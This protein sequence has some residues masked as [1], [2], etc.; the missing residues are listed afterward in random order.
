MAENKG[1]KYTISIIIPLL[2]IVA[3]AFFVV[4]SAGKK[5][6]GY[7]S[8]A[9]ES[10]YIDAQ[11]VYNSN[12]NYG[13]LKKEIEEYAARVNKELA[14]QLAREHNEAKRTELK[15]LA[16]KEIELYAET[17]LQD[18]DKDV[19]D[20]INEVAENKNLKRV[21]ISGSVR[22]NGKNMTQAVITELN[23]TVMQRIGGYFDE[24]KE[25]QTKQ[26]PNYE[27]QFN[28]DSYPVAKVPEQGVT[29]EASGSLAMKKKKGSIVAD[30]QLQPKDKEERFVWKQKE[31][32]TAVK[33]APAT[34]EAEKH[35][36][37]QKIYA[38][39]GKIELPSGK[40]E[41]IA[42]G[43]KYALSN[44]I[45]YIQ[46]RNAALTELEIS[47]SNPVG[48]TIVT[49]KTA[50]KQL[51]T[52]INT[53]I[54]PTGVIASRPSQITAAHVSAILN[55]VADSYPFA[56]ASAFIQAKNAALT[57]LSMSVPKPSGKNTVAA[58]I[59][60]QQPKIK[61]KAAVN[62]STVIAS[63]PTHITPA[64]I[65]SLLNTVSVKT[66]AAGAKF[67]KYTPVVIENTEDTMESIAVKCGKIWHKI[68]LSA[69]TKKAQPVQTSRS[70][71]G[72]TTENVA[73]TQQPVTQN[74]VEEKQVE[75][76]TR[77]QQT[78][79][80]Q[81]EI[82]QT[83]QPEQPKAEN[84]EQKPKEKQSETEPEK[85]VSNIV[86]KRVTI[87]V[88]ACLNKSGAEAA[89]KKLRS[90]HIPARVDG[91][92]KG[93]TQWWCVRVTAVGNAEANDYKQKLAAIG[94]SGIIV[95]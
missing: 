45:A 46:A 83:K 4:I 32:K 24:P 81:T 59:A 92:A 12:K 1:K 75:A 66:Y 70:V 73:V 95:R 41:A 74:A 13:I 50:T 14:G 15:H 69:N 60:T 25:E 16:K 35:S 10:G 27:R 3:A 57:E 48:K 84:T 77:V 7:R 94:Y 26:Q 72:A 78:A 91:I 88:A 31:L 56:T 8:R 80:K 37:T 19:D 9:T 71:T 44:S 90:K 49:S 38:N 55:S 64:Q 33:K 58:K 43:C 11:A 17:L 22:Q 30:T 29:K 68:Y 52:G 21:Y 87:Q 34:K 51:S 5:Q 86:S 82:M 85:T 79:D 20:A 23:M 61:N 39:T 2:L 67:H 76:A 89:V 40:A 28:F 36:K 47:A 18:I 42:Q 63:R 62:V 65:A 93:G 54:K 53:E 6:T